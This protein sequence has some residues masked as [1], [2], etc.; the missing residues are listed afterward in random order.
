MLGYFGAGLII[1]ALY[2]KD[3]FKK[4]GLVRYV[5]LMVMYLIMIG[6]PIKIGLRLVFSIK[7]VILTPWFK[8]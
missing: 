2:F 8:I 3:L 1:P 6:I 7:Y 5:P 4:L